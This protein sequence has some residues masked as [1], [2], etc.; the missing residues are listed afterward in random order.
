MAQSLKSPQVNADGTVTFRL[1]AP[2]AKTVEVDYEDR[3]GI[4][5]LEMKKSA[6]GTWT[7]T[8]L[9][10]VPDIYSYTL[11]MDGVTLIDPNV[12][13]FVPNHFDQGGVFTVPATPPAAW[14]QTEVAH[15]DV[16]HHFFVSKIAGEQQD[17]YVYTP[18]GF[19]PRAKTKYPVLYLL[20]GYSDFA[21]G[22]TVMGHANFILDNLIAGGKAKPMIVVMPYGYGAPQLLESGWNLDHNPLWTTNIERFNDVLLQEIIPQ[23]E[24]EYPVKKDREDRAIAGLSMGGAESLYTGLNH[25]DEFAWIGAMSAAILDDPARTFAALDAKSAAKLKLLWIA[26]GREDDLV[27]ANV[28]FESWLKSKDIKY[29]AVLTVGAHTWG[30][31]RRNLVELAPQLFR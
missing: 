12:H 24:R 3:S 10:L 29:V 27:T 31:W 23:V 25:I 9:Q 19:D 28:K 13:E 5:K 11:V 6:D 26:C 8:S 4:K 21:N 17:Y 22:W 30:V 14:E 16:H 18:P 2:A 20:H 15:G 7:A 1:A